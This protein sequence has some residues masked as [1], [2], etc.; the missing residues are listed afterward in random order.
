MKSKKDARYLNVNIN[1]EIYEKL[2]IFSKHTGIS[3]TAAVEQGLSLF[4]TDF[5]NRNPNQKMQ[6][7]LEGV[8]NE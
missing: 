1:R 2:E 6:K 5:C 7:E 8:A 4:I 3:K